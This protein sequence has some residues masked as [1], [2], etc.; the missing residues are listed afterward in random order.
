MPAPTAHQL[1]RWRR[2]AA[3][4]QQRCGEPSDR[5]GTDSVAGTLAA[6]TAVGGFRALARSLQEDGKPMPSGR[7]ADEEAAACW[8]VVIELLASHA[9]GF[10]FQ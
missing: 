8:A 2:W 3:E 6:K 5:T 1:Y 7:S 9:D 10:W 4:A